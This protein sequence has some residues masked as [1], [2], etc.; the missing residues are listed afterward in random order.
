MTLRTNCQYLQL[1]PTAKAL[2]DPGAAGWS[3]MLTFENSPPE[4]SVA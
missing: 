3:A 1:T 2:T 4:A